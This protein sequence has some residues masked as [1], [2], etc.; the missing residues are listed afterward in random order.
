MDLKEGIHWT[1]LVKYQI[2][3]DEESRD[4]VVGVLTEVP[5]EYREIF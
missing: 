1:L 2:T 4:I 3:C 5:V